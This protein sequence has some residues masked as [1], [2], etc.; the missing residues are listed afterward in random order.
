MCAC[1]CARASL[2]VSVRVR[3]RLCTDLEGIVTTEVQQ[4]E[5]SEGQEILQGNTLDAVVSTVVQK[6][7]K[8][9]RKDK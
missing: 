8:L 7:S 1:L 9:P 5:R 2:R 3:M 4:E 6:C